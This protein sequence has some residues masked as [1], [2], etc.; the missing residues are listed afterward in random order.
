MAHRDTSGLLVDGPANEFL[1]SRD[2]Y[3]DPEVFDWEMRHVFEGVW[4]LVGLES[5]IAAPNDFLS[6]FVGRSPVIVM[7]DAAGELH[8]V[9]NSC[10]HKGALVCHRQQGNAKR[11][12]CQYHGWAYD[13]S[14][15]NILIK[16]RDDGAYP[17]CFDSGSHDLQPVPRFAAYRGMM[18]ASLNPDVPDL[19]TYLG[20]LRAFIDLIVDQSP[21]GVE[22]LPGRGTF[23]FNG[24][25]KLQMENGV[26]PYHFSSTHP[27]YLQA[28]QRR[29]NTTSTYSG[30]RSAE[31]ERGTFAFPHGH[32]A[33]WGPAP[34]GNNTPLDGVRDELAQRVGRIKAKWMSYVR[35]VTVFPNA[36][37]ADNA[38]LQLRI[39]RPLSVDRTEMKTFCL[40]P[41]GEAPEARRLRI[42][43]YEDFFNPSGLATPD[44]ITNY[45]DCQRGFSARPVQWQQG[46]ARGSRLLTDGIPDAA[47]ELGIRPLSSVIGGFNLGDET[48][49]QPT[50]RYWRELIDSGLARD[51]G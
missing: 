6:T 47:T 18:F 34:A 7:R 50:Y 33:M 42:R 26:D 30:F 25:W 14:G 20:D 29:S 11:F 19:E 21:L 1:V 31:L 12:V 24:N 23:T 2:V 4:N 46:H 49:M 9:F 32:N 36:Q 51:A 35:N 43:Q 39:W 27:S 37:F 3:R 28:L 48:V 15:G 41:V 5:Q 45:E 10:R 44:D 17:E 22:C 13:S 16:N 8:C 40:A 38:S